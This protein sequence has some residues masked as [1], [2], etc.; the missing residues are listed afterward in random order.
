[1]KSQMPLTE[2]QRAL[3]EDNLPLVRQTIFEHI[4]INESICGLGYDDLFQ[5]GSLALCH[6]A[7]TYDETHRTV[8]FSAY[9]RPVIRNRLLDY[10]RRVVRQHNSLPTVSLDIPADEEYSRPRQRAETVCDDTPEWDTLIQMQQLFEHGKRT[11]NGVAQLGV[12]ALELKCKGL[13]GADIAR[14]Y[15]TSPTHVGAWISRA[16]SKLKKDGTALRF[17]EYV[18]EQKVS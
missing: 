2:R 5:E 18:P 4:K 8:P 10:C 7:A 14:L 15:N 13:T 11:Y 3:A 16:A 6:A 12:E 1:M 9:A 17:L